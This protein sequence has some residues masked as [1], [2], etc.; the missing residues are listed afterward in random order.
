MTMGE[1]KYEDGRKQE[2]RERRK[3]GGQV[4][5]G[6]DEGRRE[7]KGRTGRGMVVVVVILTAAGTGDASSND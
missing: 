7:I 3:E 5:K 2:E 1:K 6:M 4:R